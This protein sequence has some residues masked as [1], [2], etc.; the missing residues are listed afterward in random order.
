MDNLSFIKKLPPMLAGKRL[1]DALT[2]LPDY[3]PEIVYENEAVRLMALSDMY[4]IFVPT[5]MA[6]EIYTRMYLS[7]LRS[8]EKKE[9]KIAV[10]Q[11]NENHNAV[12]EQSYS[13]I[14]GGSDSFTIIGASGIGK[15]SAV[16]R[17]IQLL[18]AEE[19]IEIKKPFSKIIPCVLVQTPFDSS[20]KGLLYEI[21]RVVDEKLGSKYYANALRARSTTDML[22]GAVSQV[23]LNHIG[24]LVVDEIQHVVNH[25]NGKTLVNCLT[26]LINNSGISIAM[27]GTPESAVFFTQAMQLARR[28]L[29]LHYEMLEY[30]QEFHN[31]C[32]ILYTYQYVR[33]RTELDAATIQWLY[34]HSSGNISTVVTLIHDAQEIAILNGTEVLNLD[35]LRAA[36]QSRAA[37]LHPYITPPKKRQTS[38]PMKKEPILQV[39]QPECAVQE[40]ESVQTL[41]LRA[42]NEC[43]DVVSFLQAYLPVEVVSV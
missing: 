42:K 41:I 39:E 12:R 3:D 24:L 35:T 19:V 17:A 4:R 31:L 1:E 18:T 10:K 14:I 34:E 11:F 32:E 43:R 20:I 22:I 21:L 7:L 27:V 36:Y 9:S 23:A 16:T 8:L 38:A 37:M 29:G 30:G 2:I 13:G 15:S 33:N 28:A 40:V 25:K 5:Q 26:Q 6:K